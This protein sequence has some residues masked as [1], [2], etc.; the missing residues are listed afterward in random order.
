MVGEWDTDEPQ[1]D[2]S[3]SRPV[4]TVVIS[5]A[6]PA[7]P[8]RFGCLAAAASIIASVAGQR[9]PRDKGLNDAQTDPAWASAG[10][11]M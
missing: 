4:T 7:R 3:G 9:R 11:T 2:P 6:V 8:A 1:A 10:Q 5:D